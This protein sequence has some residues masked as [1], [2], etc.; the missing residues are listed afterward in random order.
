MKAKVIL[1]GGACDGQVIEVT[2]GIGMIE[3]F[4][5]GIQCYRKTARIEKGMTVY[6]SCSR[7]FG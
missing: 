2:V 6:E 4:N 7:W 3:K 5:N 1:R